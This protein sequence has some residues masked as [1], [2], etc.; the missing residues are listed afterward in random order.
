MRAIGAALIAALLAA[1]CV[2]AE[3]PDQ[4][5]CVWLFQQY[6]RVARLNPNAVQ[7]RGER[8]IPWGSELDRLWR[9]MIQNDCQTRPG[10]LGDLAALSGGPI[11]EGGAPLGRAVA[12]HVGAFTSQADTDA[13]IALFRGKGLQATSIGDPRLGRRVYVGPVTT[14]GALDAVLGTAFEAGF[15]APYPS[16]FFRF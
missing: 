9:L 8:R 6:D 16:E 13:A 11:R 2:P 10:D 5:Q 12:V 4:S 14:Q 1:A 7:N 3:T 15:V